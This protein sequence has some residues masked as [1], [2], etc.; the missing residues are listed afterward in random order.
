MT[1]QIYSVVLFIHVLFGFTALA[2]GLA[3]LIM[4]KGDNRHVLI[5]RVYYYGMAGVFFTTLFLLTLQPE[6]ESLWF[7]ST[8][9]IVSFYQT[10]TGRRSV[11]Q[12]KE[13]LHPMAL[14]WFALSLLF[15][16][17]LCTGFAALYY[18]LRGNWFMVGLFSFFSWIG[19]ATAFQDFKLFTGKT[20]VGKSHWIFHHIS[21]MVASYAATVTAFMVN[22]IPRY[23]PD[24]THWL[25]FMSIWVF[26]GLLIGI[27]GN[28]FTKPLK[29]GVYI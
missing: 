1:T 21:R 20:T 23:L 28:R 22:I 24:G 10:F 8:V 27:L 3:V 12:K 11:Q 15:L 18:G 14:D 19:F 16:T 6:R 13:G 9:A 17:G 29:K 4:K 5:G 7:L 25:V 2:T 26:P